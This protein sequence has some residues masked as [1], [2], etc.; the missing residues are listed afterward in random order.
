[1]TTVHVIASRSFA[2]LSLVD[3]AIRRLGSDDTLIA[4]GSTQVCRRAVLAATSRGL[5]ARNATMLRDR[6]EF[7]EAL[8]AGDAV[9]AFVARAPGSSE[10]TEGMG[11][12]LGYFAARGVSPRVAMSPLSGQTC[13]LIA[14]HHGLVDEALESRNEHRQRILI[15]RVL[16]ANT[17][18]LEARER[19]EA[20]LAAGMW[21][22]AD[23]EAAT[24]RWLGWLHAYECIQHE[25]EEAKALLNGRQAA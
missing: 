1:M 16:K 24:E 9:W 22:M 6:A 11:Q 2:P 7:V 4:Y 18:L 15:E 25:L 17:A 13:E 5:D 20:K 14:T 23:D 3:D 19:Y 21:L 12:F 8:R 10:P